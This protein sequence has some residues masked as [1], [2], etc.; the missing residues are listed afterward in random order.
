[1]SA[2]SATA[3]TVASRILRLCRIKRS[4]NRNLA[5]RKNAPR[6]ISSTD[7]SLSTDRPAL[8]LPG[9]VMLRR[10]MASVVPDT[11]RTTAAEYTH[12]VLGPNPRLNP[13][14]GPRSDH[15]GERP[16][17]NRHAAPSTRRI[18]PL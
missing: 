4:E 17:S 7:C 13:G 15:P 5:K 1:M 14:E 2:A 12:I 8:T 10:M 3:L 18:D 11:P 16:G 6:T 9:G